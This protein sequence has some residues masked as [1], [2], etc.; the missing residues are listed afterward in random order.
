M[1]LDVSVQIQHVHAVATSLYEHKVQHY[2][3]LKVGLAH[4]ECALS[5]RELAG[6]EDPTDAS[7]AWL[8][9][10]SNVCPSVLGRTTTTSPSLQPSLDFTRNQFQS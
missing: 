1:R 6:V 10:M 3:G 4:E 7:G 5:V 9:L 8:S 2:S